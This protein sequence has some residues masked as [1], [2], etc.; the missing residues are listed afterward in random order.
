MAN[1]KIIELLGDQADSLLNH[2]CKTITKSEIAHPNPNHIDDI[3]RISN[4]NNQTLKSLQQIL[5]HGRLGGTGYV[6]ILRN[7]FLPTHPEIP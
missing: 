5:G 6:S 7:Y 1:K 4:R 3:W 2:E